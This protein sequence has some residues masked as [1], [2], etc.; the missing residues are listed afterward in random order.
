VTPPAVSIRFDADVQ[1]FA[2]GQT[3]AG[4]YRLEGVRPGEIRA[5]ELSVLWHT[6][7]KGDEDL[8]VHEFLR[9]SEEEGGL[10]APGER[11]RF[12]TKLP[13]SPLSYDGAIVK[14][15]WS[16]RVRAFLRGGKE[17]LGE[18]R[19]RLGRVPPTRVVAK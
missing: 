8:S 12:E 13:L 6:E 4:D 17:V 1:V 2:P 18:R 16:V 15:C 7:G 5:V 19:F 9:R 10:P 3:L 14:V 11:V